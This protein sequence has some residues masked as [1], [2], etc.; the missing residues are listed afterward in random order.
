MLGQLLVY[1]L[2]AFICVGAIMRPYVGVMGYYGFTLLMP[3]WNWRWSIAQDFPYQKLIAASLLI[4]LLVNGLS[5][6]QVGR[7]S[8]YACFALFAFL[9]IAF[10]S[11]LFSIEPTKSAW[12]MNILW[13]IVLLV[14]ITVKEID[15]PK[16]LMA[17]LVVVVVA[18]SYNS[19]Q[20]NLEYFQTGFSRYAYTRWGYKG[21]NNGYSLITIPTLAMSLSLFLTAN[22]IWVRGICGVIAILQ[23]HQIMLLMSRGAMLGAIVAAAFMIVL[24][25]KNKKTILTMVLALAATAVLTGPSIIDEFGSSFKSGEERD[26]SAESRFELWKAGFDITVDYP[27]LGVGP[28]AGRK[29]VPRYSSAFDRDQKALHNLAFEVSTGCGVPAFL[30][31]VSYFFIPATFAGLYCWRT[32]RQPPD[33]KSTVALAVSCGIC[34]YW[35]GSMFSSGA[36]H[37]SSYVLA[38]MGLCFMS[39]Q[40]RENLELERSLHLDEYVEDH[41]T[42]DDELFGSAAAQH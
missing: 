36:L 11:S 21:D 3:E 28:D 20:I 27:V 37:E 9:A 34:G 25:P 39:I 41:D 16:K 42:N 5:K 14:L 12:F 4:G 17:L 29:L 13:K 19:F 40:H 26:G 22:K 24:M 2:L 18:H 7:K 8:S 15:T 38:A 33:W 31:Y 23:A 30:L 6:Y 10:V 35:V 1:G 32:Q